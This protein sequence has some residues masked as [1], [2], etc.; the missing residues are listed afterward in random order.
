MNRKPFHYFNIVYISFWRG[1]VVGIEAK[2]LPGRSGGRIPVGA[3]DF[4]FSKTCWPAL[5]PTQPPTQWQLDFFPGGKATGVGLTYHLHVVPRL[6]MSGAI[7]LLPYTPSRHGQRNLYLSPLE[8]QLIRR[9]PLISYAH[10]RV[11]CWTLT[12]LHPWR[13]FARKA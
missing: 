13:H 2:L 5:W 12:T 8:T 11:I 1:S 7:P 10:I 4:L 9:R 3:R 6:L